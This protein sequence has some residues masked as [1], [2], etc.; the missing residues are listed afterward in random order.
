MFKINNGKIT[1]T[2]QGLKISI[3]PLKRRL[4]KSGDGFVIHFSNIKMSC[5]FGYWSYS[6][7]NRNRL[8]FKSLINKLDQL[9]EKKGKL[10]SNTIEIAI[11]DRKTDGFITKEIFGKSFDDV[12]GYAPI[13]D[14]LQFVSFCQ[15]YNMIEKYIKLL[16]EK[17]NIIEYSP[18]TPTNMM[19]H[20]FSETAKQL[21]G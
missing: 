1:I 13:E 19:E 6:D 15:S 4:K 18:I 9:R 2:F 16:R 14:W 3:S 8:Q 12:I 5:I 7:N 17:E 11:L 20:I 10:S 21:K